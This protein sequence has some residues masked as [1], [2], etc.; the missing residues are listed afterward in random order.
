M[1][2]RSKIKVGCLTL[3]SFIGLVA[4][5]IYLF[6]TGIITRT[7]GFLM[8]VMFFGMY[9]GFGILIVSYRFVNKLDD[10]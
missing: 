9:V 3:L 5:V 8:V 4:I 7:Q 10:D 2:S 1:S 6:G